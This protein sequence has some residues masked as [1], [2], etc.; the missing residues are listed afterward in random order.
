MCK[1]INFI[2]VLGV[3]SI[4]VIITAVSLLFFTTLM[5]AAESDGTTPVAQTSITKAAGTGHLAQNS[6]ESNSAPNG[7]SNPAKE[8]ARKAFISEAEI[9]IKDTHY[10]KASLLLGKAL[11]DFPEDKEIS[12]LNDKAENLEKQLIIYKGKIYHVFFHSLIVYPELCFT[13]DSMEQGYNDWMTTVREFKLMIQ[14]MYER[15]YTLVDL[16]DLFKID[17]SGKMV[18]QDIYLPEG[19]KPLVISVDDMSYYKYMEKDGFAKKLVLDKAGKLASLI[20]TP[21]GDEIISKDGD[22]V[23]ILN[24]FIEEY[25]D[26]SFKG[27]KGTLALTGYEGILGYRTNHNNPDWQKERDAVVPIVDK[28]KETGWAF[29]SHSYTHRRTFSE[30]TITLDYLKYDTDKWMNEVG[31]IV[32]TTNIYIAPFGATFRQNDARQRYIVSRGFNVYCGVGPQP[33]YILYKD[34]AYMERLDLDG[35]KMFHMPELMKDLFDV[36][37]VFDPARPGF[38]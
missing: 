4:I 35:Y 2:L 17:A 8:T 37:K 1:K 38:K 19:Q 9:L 3:I 25:P 14:E 26:F 33:S 28:L 31:S 32:G 16:R 29:A 30:G 11:M 20:N 7:K 6:P 27:A 10:I 36:D 15:G 12:V 18:R 23:P 34:N 13:G 21:R 24:N 5:P 22:V